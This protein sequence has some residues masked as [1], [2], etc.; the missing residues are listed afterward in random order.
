MTG[1]YLMVSVMVGFVG[2]L[3]LIDWLD[4]R[5]NRKSGNRTA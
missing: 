5:K 4:R 1:Y 2:I 3:T